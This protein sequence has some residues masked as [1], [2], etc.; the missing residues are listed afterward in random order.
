MRLRDLFTRTWPEGSYVAQVQQWGE[1]GEGLGIKALE[2]PA[3]QPL[4]A[5]I[6]K[7]PRTRKPKPSIV[8]IR[9]QA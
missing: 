3:I 6:A 2:L 7:R 1:S 9:R 4:K 5:Q 8:R